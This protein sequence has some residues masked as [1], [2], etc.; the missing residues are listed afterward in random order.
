MIQGSDF[1]VKVTLTDSTGAL[2]SIDALVDLTITIYDKRTKDVVDTFTKSDL[3]RVSATEYT[4]LLPKALTDVFPI[5]TLWGEGEIQET[6]S[7]FTGNIR[8]TKAKE[9][10]DDVEDTVIP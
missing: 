4:L 3:L 8:R 9:R 1:P 10:I 5:S 6:D 2:Q 7:R